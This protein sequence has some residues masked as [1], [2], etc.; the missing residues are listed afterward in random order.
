MARGRRTDPM[1]AALVMVL[2]D[3]GFEPGM[4]AELAKLPRGTVNNITLGNDPWSEAPENELIERIKARLIQAIDS[5]P[6]DLGMAAIAKLDEKIKTA[7]IPEL[8]SIAAGLS[9]IGKGDIQR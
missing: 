6:Y 5:T 8:I 7:S 1:K 2:A 9:G 3:M 4:I